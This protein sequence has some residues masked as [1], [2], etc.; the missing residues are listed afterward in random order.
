MNITEKITDIINTYH[1]TTIEAH[2]LAYLMGMRKE[3]SVYA[4]E[5]GTFTAKYKRLLEETKAQRKS[6]FAKQ[7]LKHL[8]DSTL[9]KAE[10]L[11]EQDI[12]EIRMNEA[13]LDGNYIG[14][15]IILEQ[16][17][18]VINSMQQDIS[19]LKLEYKNEL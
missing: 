12:E 18:E 15:K 16:C 19:Q 11:A 8:E 9:G 17:N 3:L 5:L 1:A 13:R 6:R 4:F 10:L 7:K 14:S 2:N